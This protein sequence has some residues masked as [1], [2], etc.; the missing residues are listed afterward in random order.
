MARSIYLGHVPNPFNLPIPKEWWLKPIKDYD[1]ELRVY[2]SQTKPCYRLAR[3][4]RNSGRLGQ[5]MLGSI[6]GIHPDSKVALEHSLVAVTTIP[7]MALNAPPHNIVEQLRRRDQW[8]FGGG[9]DLEAGDRVADQLDANDAIIEA[10][11]LKDIHDK[12]I[13]RHEAA[14]ISLLYRTGARVSLVRPPSFPTGI[15]SRLLSA[16]PDVQTSAG[17][18]TP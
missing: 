2:P 14:R 16:T 12:G 3:V 5:R 7:P 4:A 10:N 8:A 1:A 17:T 13:P 15:A 11:K 18:P 6:P 9:N